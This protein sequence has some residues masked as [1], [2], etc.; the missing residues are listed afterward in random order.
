MNE[1][2][3]CTSIMLPIA[4]AVAREYQLGELN[5]DV[6]VRSIE[7]ES[8]PLSNDMIKLRKGKSIRESSDDKS[9]L[10]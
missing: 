7:D 9:L 6:S 10:C 2:A 3:A 8:K 1:S 4:L 5:G